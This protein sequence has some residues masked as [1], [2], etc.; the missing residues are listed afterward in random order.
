MSKEEQLKLESSILMDEF[1][2][3]R[4][5]ILFQVGGSRQ[6][7]NLTLT[8]AGILIA[9]T[10]FIVQSKLISLFLIIPFVFYALA[11]AQIRYLS[12]VDTLGSY[13]LTVL[14]PRVRQ[15]LAE[16]SPN[17]KR[18]FESILSWDVYW[19]S[20]ERHSGILLLPLVAS[21]YGVNLLVAILSLTAYFVLVYQLNLNILAIDVVMTVLN[22]IFFLYTIFLGFW[23]R[24]KYTRKKV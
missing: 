18:D 1:K 20:S 12:T 8:G 22:V 19:R 13:L 24:S 9:G 11:W 2:A 16:I 10:P 23:A 21:N 7:I 3:L 5:E 6:V 17:S 14:T 4:E 15:V